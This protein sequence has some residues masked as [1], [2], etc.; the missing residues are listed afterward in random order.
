MMRVEV[1]WMRALA[2]G[3]AATAG[4]VDAVAA[5]AS[6][7]PRDL[8]ALAVAAGDAGNPVVP[9]VAGLRE[10]VTDREAARLMHRG[11]TSQDVLDTALMLLARRALARV[12]ADLDVT[13][14][15]LAGLASRH[16]DTVRAGRTLTQYAVPITFGLKVAH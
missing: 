14:A 7:W 8:V 12:A 2:E 5:A 9:L 13:A 3:G 15:V 6:S 1:A 4:Q 16:R 10:R 11:L